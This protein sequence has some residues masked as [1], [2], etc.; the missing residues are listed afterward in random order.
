MMLAKW[1][2]K[3][4]LT[5]STVALSPSRKVTS[6]NAAQSVLIAAVAAKT[7]T[8]PRLTTKTIKRQIRSSKV[9]TRQ[10]CR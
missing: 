9:I 6:K 2:F 10:T 5:V 3:M 7:S 1:S 8:T 4:H